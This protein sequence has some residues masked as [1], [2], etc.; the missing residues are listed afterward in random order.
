MASIFC[1]SSANWLASPALDGGHLFEALGAAVVGEPAVVGGAGARMIHPRVV[2]A[3][4][5]EI[6]GGHPGG[7]ARQRRDGQIEIRTQPVGQGFTAGQSGRLAGCR[8]SST[9]CRAVSRFRKSGGKLSLLAASV[10]RTQNSAAALYAHDFGMLG[11]STNIN[12]GPFKVLVGA[13]KT[14]RA[15]SW[16]Q[17]SPS[18]GSPATAD[19]CTANTSGGRIQRVPQTRSICT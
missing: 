4:V 6:D 2:G 5:V 17:T 14:L 1:S 19:N 12:R 11:G 13:G 3:A 16:I 10:R 7:V 8:R 15:A 9:G 18:C